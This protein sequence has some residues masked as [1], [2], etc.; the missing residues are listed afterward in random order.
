MGGR[1]LAA[2][3]KL[4]SNESFWKQLL[5]LGLVEITYNFAWS[6]CIK[7]TTSLGSFSCETPCADGAE[8]PHTVGEPSLHSSCFWLHAHL[9]LGLLLHLLPLP[10]RGDCILWFL[11]APWHSAWPEEKSV[12]LSMASGTSCHWNSNIDTGSWWAPAGQRG[13]KGPCNI[14]PVPWI[15][16]RMLWV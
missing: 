2:P 5:T 8:H 12:C 10:F 13:H 7:I 14:Q 9:A 11:F 6:A 4:C 1:L 16:F 15:T 3:V